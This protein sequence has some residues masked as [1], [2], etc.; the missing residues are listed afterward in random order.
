MP[1][2]ATPFALDR[3]DG[4]LARMFAVAAALLSIELFSNALS[5]RAYLHGFWFWVPFLMV[6]VSQLGSVIGAFFIGDMKFWYRALTFSTLFALATWPLEVDNLGA[7]PAGFKPWVWWAIGFS[8]LAAVGAFREFVALAVMLLIP[9]MWLVIRTSPVGG[10]TPFAEAFEDS[11]YS[12]FFSTSMALL[13]MALRQQSAKVDE[14]HKKRLYAVAQSTTL[15]AIERERVRIDA[16]AHGKVLSSLALAVT[17]DSSENRAAAAAA[18]NDA[19]GRLERESKRVPD[20]DAPV[21]TA[22][23]VDAL[24]DMVQSQAP[25]VE[26][27]AKQLHVSQV[28][29]EQAVTLAEVTVEAALN[30]L[31][32]ANAASKHSVTLQN[33]ASGLKITVSDDGNGF[34]ISNLSRANLGVRRVILARC[35]AF[36]IKVNLSTAEG[37]RWIFEVKHSARGDQNA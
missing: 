29:F 12:F 7:L 19:I 9:I 8:A 34:R 11:L 21:S 32:H 30:S 2:R 15:R 20:G 26:Y 37:T 18:A 31:K 14:A 35:R 1:A 33:T 23:F 36:E 5:Q 25:G 3:I 22:T 16:I 17:P 10:S 4:L 24:R 13:V 28:P 6:V 27:R